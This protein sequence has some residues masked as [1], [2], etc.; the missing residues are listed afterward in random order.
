MTEHEWLGSTDTRRMVDFIRRN[1]L[2][3]KRK[4]RLCACHCAKLIDWKLSKIGLKVLKI[5][6]SSIHSTKKLEEDPYYPISPSR[7]SGLWSQ[8]ERDISM[9]SALIDAAWLKRVNRYHEIVRDIFGNPFHIPSLDP[10]VFAWK[11]GVIQNIAQVIYFEGRFNEIP[12][13]ADALEEA[14]CTDEYLLEHCRQPF[15][16]VHGCWV[17]DFLLDKP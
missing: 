6:E 7:F 15:E 8:V 14:G 9:P 5:G 12:V 17:L 1:K 2:K 13:L 11:D 10:Y 4:F 16:H 3:N